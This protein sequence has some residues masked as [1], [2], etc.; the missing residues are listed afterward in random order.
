EVTEIHAGKKLL[1][2]NG[3]RSYK[4]NELVWTADLKR[5]YS[6]L[7]TEG[8]PEAV[9]EKVNTFRSELSKKHGTDSIFS[10]F[11]AVDEPPEIFE[12]ISNGHFFYTPSRKGLGEIHRSQLRD[13]LKNWSGNSKEEILDWLDRFCEL[14]TYEISIPV[15]K[16]R[17]SAPP[18]KT[19]LIISTLFEYEIVKKVHETGWYSEFKEEFQ[20]KII[21]VL[22]NS[23]YPMLKDKVLF[24]FSSS[25]LSVERA[26]G[27]FEGSIVGWSFEEPIPVV[28]SM[29]KVTDS[30][31]TPIPCV[32]QAGKWTY[33]PSGVPMCILTG[34]LAAREVIRRKSRENR[35]T[36]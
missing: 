33:S 32:L 7:E 8:L 10:V 18:G 23:I 20:K 19:G 16:D 30:V 3:G 27:S 2:D 24:A 1:V 29:M 25:P 21:E 9:V 15:L 22:S 17:N 34:K 14:D 13:L 5:L 35:M 26:V 36:R 12:A 4:Y 11:V 28:S 6:I 31:K